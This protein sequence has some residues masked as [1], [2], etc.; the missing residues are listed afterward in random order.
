MDIDWQI[1]LII[2]VSLFVASAFF[3]GSEIA[4]FSLNKKN[5]KD[6]I[7]ANPIIGRYLSQLLHYPR[8]LLVTILIGNTIVN[9]AAS[10]IAVS[11][12][13]DIAKY[14]SISNELALT[15]QIVLLT[16]LIVIFGEL[17]PKVWA[18]KEPLK[19]SKMCAVPLYFMSTVLYPV[20]EFITEIIKI[21]VSKLRIE[22]FNKAMKP[23]ELA[24]LA[25]LSHEK[26]TIIEEEQGLI[27]SIVS[28]GTVTVHEVMTP[29]VDMVSVSDDLNIHELLEIINKSGHSRIPLFRKDLDDIIGIVYAKDLLTYIKKGVSHN[30]FSLTSIS[31]KSMFVPKTKMI[32]NLL[33][34]FQEKKM[35]IAVVVDEYGGTA[36]V[37][38]LED[39]LEE[40]IGEIRD[41]FDKEEN[42]ISKLSSANGRYSPAEISGSIST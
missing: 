15:F 25:K 24:E 7:S 28:F 6:E 1:K 34:E 11:L 32:S 20:S 27:H 23:E 17:I 18:S 14:Y 16:V 5:L 33:Q 31:R 37:V 39:I 26:G 8:R 4:L 19:F 35:H 3:S 41:E 42:T 40:I 36:G 29:R 12:A 2:I 38:T 13:L 21:S 9:V 30:E 10:I 22:K